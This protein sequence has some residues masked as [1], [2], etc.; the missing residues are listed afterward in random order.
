MCY[1]QVIASKIH[2]ATRKTHQCSWCC[3]TVALGDRYERVRARDGGDIYT[4]HTHVECVEAFRR[5]LEETGAH[6][7][8]IYEEGMARGESVD[9]MYARVNGSSQR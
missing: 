7:G 1:G 2:K 9:E 8:C 4:T 3:E 6:D 5:S